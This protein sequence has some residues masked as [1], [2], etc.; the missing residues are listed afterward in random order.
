MNDHNRPYITRY[1]QKISKNLYKNS[2]TVRNSLRVESNNESSYAYHITVN[3]PT[4]SD[5]FKNN[6]I[7]VQLLL[8]IGNQYDIESRTVAKA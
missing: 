7:D 5:I 3:K 4:S 1:F 6:N 2:D 8:R